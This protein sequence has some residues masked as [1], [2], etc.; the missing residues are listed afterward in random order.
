VAEITNSAV[1]GRASA[2]DLI[3]K[4][5]QGAASPDRD[6]LAPLTAIAASQ[7]RALTDARSRKNGYYC[8]TGSAVNASARGR[9][10]VSA[11]GAWSDASFGARRHN[12][13]DRP[14]AGDFAVARLQES[15]CPPW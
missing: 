1:V 12:G 5:P 4:R 7:W 14:G 8:L 2:K 11:L 13:P 9:T 3:V 6:A 10:G 15:P